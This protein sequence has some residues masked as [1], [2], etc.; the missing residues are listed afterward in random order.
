MTTPSAAQAEPL[1]AIVELVSRA[2]SGIDQDVLVTVIERVGGGRAKRRRLAID[3]ARDP[4]VL[5]TGRSPASKAVGD[6][7][8]ALRAAGATGIAPPLCAECGRVIGSM[9]RRGDH[10]YC[11]P[12]FTRPKTCASCGSQRK[13]SFRDRNGQP[14]CSQ[15]PDTDVR[16]P[17]LLLLDVITTADPTLTTDTINIVLDKVVTKPAHLRKLAWTLEKN[18]GLLTGDGA[19]APFPMVLRLIEELC[20]AGATSI[21]R[22]AC[23]GCGRVIAMSKQRDGQRICRRC[24]ARAKAVP[25]GNCGRS[26]EPAARDADENPLCSY[27]LV[28]N[29]IN[30]EECV[31]CRR[32]QRVSTRGPAGPVCASCTPRQIA[33]CSVC[34]RNLPCMTSTITGQP[35]CGGC[36]RAWAHCSRCGQLARIRAGTRDQP[37]CATCAQPGNVT[38]KICPGCGTDDRLI[39]GP[40]RRC[41]L[42]TKLNELLTDPATGTIRPDLHTFHDAL[43]DVDRPESALGW[44]RRAAVAALIAQVAAGERP[45]THEALDDLPDSK[46]LRHLRS[47]LVAAGALPERDEHLAQLE[48]WSGR[49]I[50]ERTDPQHKQILHAYAIWHVLRRLRHRIHGTRTTAQQATVARR[51]I[52]AAAAFLNWL[53]DRHL[54]LGSCPQAALDEWISNA[55]IAQRGNTGNFVR[56]AKRHKHT[57]LDLPATRW[58]GPT[59]PID[60]ETRWANARRLL[61][62]DALNPEDRVAGLLV[63]LYAQQAATIS[64]LTLDHV[65]TSGDDVRLLL[66]KEPVLLPEP[67]DTLVLQLV[68]TRRGHATIA[69]NGTSPWLLPGGRPGQPIS[70]YRLAERLHQIG[71][72][73]G[74]TRSTALFQLATGLPA[75]ILARMLGIHINVAVQWQ[76]ASSGDWMT[77]AAD[78]SRRPRT[79]NESS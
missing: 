10:W 16:D 8:L 21:K 43:T 68:A 34:G 30:L 41:H 45:L 15:C 39:T 78:V 42:H 14:R 46:T 3:L 49:L 55:S 18:P 47:V 51:N 79:T 32:R 50:S 27:C 71:I 19:S 74:P 64:R 37:L 35:W 26:S 25:C 66:G 62:D 72:Q 77:Y 4:S 57:R 63:L 52:N 5:A 7:L 38:L 2:D 24:C 70:P 48:R 1:R 59:R 31:R 53:A 33:D 44:I 36:A 67:L 22:P 20:A 54:D 23:S 58:D 13:P 9:Q 6:L 69:D 11:S 60:A 40:C 12:C 29:P 28:S 76:H 65:R 61:H 73:P 75:A 17:R 56:W